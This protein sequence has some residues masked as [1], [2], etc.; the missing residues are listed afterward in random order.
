MLGTTAKTV[1]NFTSKL[2]QM[3][4]PFNRANDPSV[5]TMHKGNNFLRVT[6]SAHSGILLLHHMGNRFAQL[7]LLLDV[8]GS[9]G[10]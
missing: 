6:A 7:C 3:W 8:S 5:T 1:K 9:D 2:N 10:P 4:V